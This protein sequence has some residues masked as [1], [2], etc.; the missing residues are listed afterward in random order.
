MS[1][2]VVRTPNLADVFAKS[3][4]TP[5]QRELIGRLQTFLDSPTLQ[6]FLLKGYAGTGKTFLMKGLVTYLREVRHRHFVLMAPTGR[7]AK[8]LGTR[9]GEH[10]ST[11]HS[12]LYGPS[13]DEDDDE[14]RLVSELWPNTDDDDTVY[15]IDESSMVSD[16]K[17]NDD[18]LSFGSGFLLADFVQFFRDVK[19]ENRRQIIFVGDAAQ[20]P[21]V[22]MSL[23]PGLDAAYLTE[24]FNFAV[25]G[26]ELTDIVRQKAESGILSTVSAIRDA[27]RKRDY[28]R[29]VFDTSK[30]DVTRVHAA[31]IPRLYLESMHGKL[32]KDSVMIAHTNVR[33]RELNR[34]F[35][36]LYFPRQS[37][38][39]V[40]D[41]VIVLLNTWIGRRFLCNGDF[42]VVKDVAPAP[43][44]HSVKVKKRGD[45]TGPSV[46][47]PVDL[48]FRRA[49]I[50]FRDEKGVLF[51]VDGMI[52]ENLLESEEGAEGQ[53]LRQALLVDFQ[54]RHPD[55]RP[56]SQA[57]HDAKAEDRYLN[58]LRVRYGY[59]VTCHKAQ[60]GE[61]ENVF[62]DCSW[63]ARRRSESY[64]RWLYTALTRAKGKLYLAC[65]PDIISS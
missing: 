6:V 18:Y 15:I 20:L 8:V 48:V 29:L 32:T 9:V 53:F 13:E 4:L 16:L 10:A 55:L 47:V 21:P 49:L 41:K 24:H 43:E 25:D 63:K 40:G 51:D 42:G 11:M 28:S 39:T 35:R 57:W 59:A 46:S 62:V 65:A 58:A 3:T 17:S 54:K 30:S 52:L 33:V 22:H 19:E 38:I 31:D 14:L 7:A 36:E 23:S 1:E 50:R 44:V 45:K 2:I 26:Y 64:F 12:K 34:Q 56:G 61:W 27:L 37:S 5:G 60:G